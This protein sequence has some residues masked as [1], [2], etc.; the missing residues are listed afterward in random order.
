MWTKRRRNREKQRSRNL[1]VNIMWENR[2]QAFYCLSGSLVTL[3]ALSIFLSEMSRGGAGGSLVLH[4][5][6]QP[7]SLDGENCAFGRVVR[8]MDIVEKI[9]S[10]ETNEED[11][12]SIPIKIVS[13]GILP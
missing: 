8:G 3:Y 11:E 10:V 1:Y 9:G 6:F 13:S 4:H 7:P 5:G 12:P 2:A